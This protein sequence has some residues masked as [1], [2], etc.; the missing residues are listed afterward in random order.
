MAI[1]PV[2]AESRDPSSGTTDS[3]SPTATSVAWGGG[4]GGMGGGWSSKV[5]KEIF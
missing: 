5:S 4:G 1:Y 2:A 3:A